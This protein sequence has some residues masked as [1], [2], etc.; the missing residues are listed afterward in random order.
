MYR[1][2]ASGLLN[3]DRRGSERLLTGTMISPW[4]LVINR[5]RQVITVIQKR[6]RAG[7]RETPSRLTAHVGIADFGHFNTTHSLMLGVLVS[8]LPARHHSIL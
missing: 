4:G 6:L 5:R 1:S 2:R 8:H 7:R 3:Q